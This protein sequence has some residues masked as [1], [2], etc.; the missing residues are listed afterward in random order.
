MCQCHIRYLNGFLT[1]DLITTQF[2]YI[3]FSHRLINKL[4]W[5]LKFHV[6]SCHIN[7]S[8]KNLPIPQV[9]IFI[10]FFWQEWKKKSNKKNNKGEPEWSL[11]W[12]KSTW[13][14]SLWCFCTNIENKWVARQITRPPLILVCTPSYWYKPT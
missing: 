3:F 1:D 5:N 13:K 4:I 6:V 8:W 12:G 11:W 10:E 2:I 9:N 14:I 7:N